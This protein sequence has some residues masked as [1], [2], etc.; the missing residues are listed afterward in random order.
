MPITFGRARNASKSTGRAV[1]V[2]PR[3]HAGDPV[4]AGGKLEQPLGFL[5]LRARLH[6]IAPSMPHASRS[7]ITSAGRKSR[8]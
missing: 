6:E 8:R 4:L 7:G 2:H 1:E 5:D 3:R